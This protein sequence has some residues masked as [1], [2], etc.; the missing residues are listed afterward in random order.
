MRLHST[1]P[2]IACAAMAALLAAPSA[3]QNQF[4]TVRVANGLANPLFLTSPPG[5]L[6]RQF[7]LEQGGRIKILKGGSV[8]PTPFLDLGPAGLGK[9]ISGGERGLL[10][11][12]FHPEYATNGYFYVDYTGASGATFVERYQVSANP[13]LA[14]PASGLVIIGPIAQP[15]SN[16]NGGCLQFGMDRKLYISLGDGGNAN[17]SGT[18]HAPGGNA[19]SGATLLGKILRLDVDLPPPYVPP[20]NPFVNDP[21]VLDEIWSM[22]LR[23]PWRFSFDRALGHMYIGDV[24]QGA[25]EEIDFEPFGA[26]GRNYGWRCMEG[27]NCTGLS[28]CTCNAPSLTLPI[29][30]YTHAFGCSVTGGYV[31]RG[32]AIPWADGVYFFADYCSARIWT[33]EYDGTSLTNFKERT[34]EMA[35]GGGMSINSITSFGQDTLGELYI[36]DFGGG[37]VYKIVSNPLPPDCNANGVADGCDIALGSSPDLNGNGIPDEC[38]CPTNPFVYCTAKMNSLFCTPAI[39]FTG[40]PKIGAAVPFVIEARQ[41][42]NQKNGL[43][44]YGFSASSTPFQGGTLCVQSP[45]QRTPVQNSGGAVG[46]QDCSGVLSFDFSAWIQGGADPALVPGQQ[47]NAQYWSRDPQGSF[48]TNLTDAVEFVIC[49]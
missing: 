12:A 22:G 31:Y 20:D 16:H 33:F 46:G 32:C 24:G 11:L 37:E 15:Q 4:K 35:P 19:Q 13:D 34:A 44:F 1:R 6:A 39:G 45:F 26:G 38:E 3:A 40:V 5:D 43:L 47:V 10:G 42:V 14:N 21:N 49:N 8:L 17:D 2:F 23:N 18:G 36:C 41:I 48:S 30:D 29:H 25:K 9:V 27:F 7:I 28:G